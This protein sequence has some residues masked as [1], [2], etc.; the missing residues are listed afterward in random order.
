MKKECF[1]YPE[2]LIDEDARVYNKE[3]GKE[4]IPLLEHSLSINGPVIYYRFNKRTRV[5]SLRSLY[6]STFIKGGKI[7]KGD[8]FDPVDGDYFNLKPDNFLKRRVKKSTKDDEGYSCWMNGSS[9]LF[10]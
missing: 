5:L 4:I 1:S 7:A 3:T 8:C 9:E 10:C 2:L 6:F